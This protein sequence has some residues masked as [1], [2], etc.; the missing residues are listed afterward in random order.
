ME[1][2]RPEEWDASLEQG[3]D[4]P[5]L[6]LPYAFGAN[7]RMRG[8]SLSALSRGC[9]GSGNATQLFERLY[10]PSDIRRAL[11]E[12]DLALLWAASG[13]RAIASQARLPPPRR[14]T[15]LASY[16]WGDYPVRSLRQQ[17][18]FLAT[19]VAAEFARA[20]ILMT[21]EQCTMACETL[22]GRVPVVRFTWGIDT[23]FYRTPATFADVPEAERASVTRLMERRFAILAGD[24]LRCEAA[25]LD[26][27]EANDATLVRV[28][29]GSDR[30]AY[31]AREI[32]K[33]RLEERVFLFKSVDYPFLRFLLQNAA[34][35]AGFVDSVWQPAGW[36]V[37][38]EA[39]A[40]GLPVV[41]Y[42]GLVSREMVRLGAGNLIQTA[43]FGDT[44]AMGEALDSF[45][46]RNQALSA[47][48][49]RFAARHLDLAVT[50]TAFADR[51]GSFAS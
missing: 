37:A 39:L 46:R 12:T 50:A 32:E 15:M 10:C 4:R 17:G 24:Q 16:V 38:C 47:A 22:G 51:I 5:R 23:A 8:H 18:L 41:L 31:V 36:T 9:T 13:I 28:P 25:A 27:A 3:S 7:L 49:Q 34:G 20:L 33:R 29:Q 2:E 19:R 48:S 35:Y 30:A 40:T 45:L 26:W 6:P 42:E 43:P 44:V 21:G 14:R 11:R 1:A